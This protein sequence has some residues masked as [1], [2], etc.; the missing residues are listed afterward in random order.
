MK[1]IKIA[2]IDS[3]VDSSHPNVGNIAGGVSIEICEN[4]EVVLSDDYYDC[5]GHGTACA[6][7]IR[8]KAPNAM[9]YSVRIFDESL[10]A[11]GRALVAAI[12]WCIE[13]EMDVVNLSL[14]TTDVTLS[15]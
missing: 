6:G 11:D 12:R 14:G 7:I 8:K 15:K 1:V 9:L 13:N 4:G 5:A 10:I 3:G 2:I